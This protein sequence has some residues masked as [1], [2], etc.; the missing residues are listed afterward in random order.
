MFL[1]GSRLQTHNCVCYLHADQT[2]QIKLS[3]LH[4]LEII[5]TDSMVLRGTDWSGNMGRALSSSA[6]Q[7]I[8]MPESF[9]LPMPTMSAGLMKNLTSPCTVCLDSAE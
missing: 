7:E 5:W 8:C 1:E 9:L 4:K 3:I 2:Q 6:L